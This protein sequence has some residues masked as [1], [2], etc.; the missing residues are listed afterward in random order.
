MP[1]ETID[2]S[3]MNIRDAVETDTVLAFDELGNMFK[4]RLPTAG[5][6]PGVPDEPVDALVINDQP[7]LTVVAGQDL[8]VTLG[9]KQ[10]S[11]KTVSYSVTGSG[12]TSLTMIDSNT[13]T[14]NSS[15]AATQVIN[16]AG[17]DGSG[18]TDTGIITIDVT[19]VVVNPPA[20]TAPV[21]NDQLNLTT[22]AGS[23]LVITL[24]ALT[25]DGDAITY[26]ISGTANYTAGPEV[27]EITFNS[28]VLGDESFTIN[29]NSGNG[30][31][32]SYADITVA[33][34][35]A[36]GNIAP[37]INDQ[38][39]TVVSGQNLTITL[40]SLTDNPTDNDVLTY[41]VTGGGVGSYTPVDANTG[42]F[43]HTGASTQTLNITASDG[44]DE[45][46]AVITIQVTALPQVAPSNI[47]MIGW[48]LLYRTNMGDPSLPNGNSY[49]SVENLLGQIYLAD[50]LSYNTGGAYTEVPSGTMESLDDAAT[51]AFVSSIASDAVLISGH[52][53]GSWNDPTEPPAWY[54]NAGNLAD[55]VIADS[56]EILWYQGWIYNNESDVN[57]ANV[58]TNYQNMKAS[59]G[60]TIIKTAEVLRH[61]QRA[62]PEYWNMTGSG[63]A[64]PVDD[65][66]A[67]AVHGS[68]ALYYMAAMTIY[69]AVTGINAK[70]AQ[71][72]VPGYFQM[73]QLFIDRINSSIDAVQD[74]FYPGIT[75]ATINSP[76]TTIDQ[77][78][79]IEEGKDLVFDIGELTDADG[80]TLTYTVLSGS[81]YIQS[82]NSITY[83]SNTVGVNALSI[84]ADDGQG[85]QKIVT[86]TIT[87]TAIAAAVGDVIWISAEVNHN[88]NSP[89]NEVVNYLNA[90]ETTGMSNLLDTQGNATTVSISHV[91]MGQNTA[92]AD[93]VGVNTGFLADVLMRGTVYTQDTQAAPALLPVTGLKPNTNYE[94]KWTGTRAG[95]GTKNQYITIGGAA[96]NFTFDA[97]EN[98][99]LGVIT[100]VNSGASGE[101]DITAAAADIGG[102]GYMYF[103][104][105]TISEVA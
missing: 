2:T 69:K 58:P 53:S 63:G 47:Q 20:N 73:D 55:A 7:S 17:D 31:G 64:L 59:K 66:W 94:I 75:G 45:D 65:L 41:T 44:I 8:S 32:Y 104:G 82:G 68:F 24:G 21:I 72:V 42:T 23:D 19:A 16:V 78:F 50:S 100:T 60:G 89:N 80:D 6:V 91:A 81:D 54:V 76:P 27:N 22:A 95:S 11:G 26:G 98:R 101:I 33:V 86:I 9:P 88:V 29:A 15:D 71:Y 14:F 92:G 36:T 12:A 67:D 70:D 25:H 49:G 77:A 48:S 51:I 93:A 74:E 56:K 43:N 84:Q 85:N 34:T 39:L 105:M 99:N 52:S 62:Y 28:A 4:A 61:F 3:L 83:N 5:S 46:T 38:N 40:G 96:N 1:A 10:N 97:G 103:T 37:V 57:W 87:V 13:G 79:S 102:N 90:A 18:G 35:V 30:A